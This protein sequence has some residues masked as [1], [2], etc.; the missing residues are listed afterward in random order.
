MEAIVRAR[1]ASAAADEKWSQPSEVTTL[2]LEHHMAADRLGF[3][4]MFTPLDKAR[5]TKTGLRSGELSMLRL[6]SKQVLPIFEAKDRGD[7]FAVAAIVRA[8]CPFLTK[9]NLT[10]PDVDQV[11][12]IAKAKAGVEQLMALRVAQPNLRFLD[13]L[14]SV[15]ASGLFEVPRTLLAFVD[16]D[17]DLPAENALTHPPDPKPVA[18]QPAD[19]T[20]ALAEDEG[21]ESEQSELLAAARA[22]LETEF[23]QIAAYRTYIA[24]QA[25]FATHHGV[26]GRQFPRVFVIADDTGAAGFSYNFERLLSSAAGDSRVDQTRRLFYVTASR[27]QRSLAILIYTED[28]ETVI[29]EVVRKGWFDQAEVEKLGT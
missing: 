25:G 23:S 1:M 22:F 16:P 15:A 9:S 14:R 13:V 26:K 12:Q 27:A 20:G 2:I 5:L 24:G 21:T 6:F 29:R 19:T 17:T 10:R 4:A 28:P 7:E 18:S 11:A 3:S 8:G